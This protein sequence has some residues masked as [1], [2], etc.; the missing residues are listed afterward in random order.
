MIVLTLFQSNKV[1]LP[2]FLSLPVALV[3]G[4]SGALISG[5]T[6]SLGSLIGFI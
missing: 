5:G 4:I 1:A 6:L 2:I 3:G